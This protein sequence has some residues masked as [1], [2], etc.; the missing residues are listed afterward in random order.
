[1]Y[2]IIGGEKTT[3]QLLRAEAEPLYSI[4]CVDTLLYRW[5]DTIWRGGTL[6][7]VTPANLVLGI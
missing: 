3:V 4:H 5:R 1:M 2:K 6:S 7:D